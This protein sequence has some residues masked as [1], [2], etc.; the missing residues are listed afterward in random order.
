MKAKF[1][2]SLRPRRIHWQ[3]TVATT[4]PDAYNRGASPDRSWYLNYDSE[5][6]NEM[7]PSRGRAAHRYNG[8]RS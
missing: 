7:L 1:R 8:F 3:L 4:P 6:S 2:E 5:G